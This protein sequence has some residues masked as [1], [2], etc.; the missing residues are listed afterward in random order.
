MHVDR[1]E[2]PAP[3]TFGP[4][5]VPFVGWSRTAYHF[6]KKAAAFAKGATVLLVGEAGSGRRT[7]ARAWQAVA[8]AGVDLP[9]IHLDRHEGELPG[10]C[11]GY[12]ER[13][14]GK[15]CRCFLLHEGCDGAAP[16]GGAAPLPAGLSGRF[17]LLLYVPPIRGHRE[18]DVLAFLDFWWRIR[19]PAPGPRYR[20]IEVALIRRLLFGT[21]WPANFAG[22]TRHLD[23][24][25]RLD[26]VEGE[27][28]RTLRDRPGFAGFDPV[29]SPPG[30]VEEI[31][32]RR[33]P[34]LAVALFLH[35]CRLVPEPG[36][37]A[38]PAGDEPPPPLL[39]EALWSRGRRDGA[40]L[41][42]RHFRQL[43]FDE[44]IREQV[45]LGLRPVTP[46]Q[47][48][49]EAHVRD[50]ALHRGAF[51]AT[52][53]SL[54]AGLAIDPRRAA[55]PL[56][57]VGAT[58]EP[59]PTS[60]AVPAGATPAADAGRERVNRFVC[61]VGKGYYLEYYPGPGL[62]AEWGSFAFDQSRGL[63][64]YWYLVHN[65]GRAM[66]AEE[67]RDTIGAMTKG[68]MPGVTAEDP[69]VA[70]L[71]SG[72]AERDPVIDYK[73]IQSAKEWLSNA[74][75]ELEVAENAGD[76]ESVRK[77]ES[78]RQQVQ[79]Y[80]DTASYRG[81]IKS[82]DETQ[83]RARQAAVRAMDHA[84]ELIAP[85][86]PYLSHHLERNVVK[87]GHRWKYDPP[88]GTSFSPHR[89]ELG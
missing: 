40:A 15:D 23:T 17:D 14:P 85:E 61:D 80:L 55:E 3:A 2:S 28:V 84:L 86:L 58:A 10:R 51:G 12:T 77:L 41:G 65:P 26:H 20:R 62:K 83:K 82:L 30:E 60:V 9:V 74:Q 35:R 43:G 25:T 18:I 34:D 63:A 38:H 1:A 53:A 59:T 22:L 66:S 19:P 31:A 32:A 39:P 52:F 8:G 70:H 45:L 11:V 81:K 50:F 37:P 16:S 68:E 13:R 49:W 24:L 56:D 42:A 89:G 27:A 72:R 6:R 7:M 69:S 33:V 36:R 44:F 29:E 67:L 57:R 71:S 79:G 78:Q 54:Q 64:Y 88:D 4:E 21:D 75:I 46:A 47:Q 5:D 76:W 73:T 48:E 87:E